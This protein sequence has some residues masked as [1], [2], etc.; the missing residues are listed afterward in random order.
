MAGVQSNEDIMRAD[1][2]WLDAGVGLLA[3]LVAAKVTEYGQQAL[4][5]LTPKHIPDQES[6]VRP[7]PP[8]RLAAPKTAA[9]VR[10][11]VEPKRLEHMGMALQVS[12]GARSIS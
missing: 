1:G 4:W 11:K 5:A 8:Y 10:L 9:T 7:G 12:R 2:A 3:G 6:R